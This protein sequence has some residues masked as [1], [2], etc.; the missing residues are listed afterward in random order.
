[1]PASFDADAAPRRAGRLDAAE[2]AEAEREL[3]EASALVERLDQQIEARAHTLPIYVATLDTDGLG[4]ELRARR[5]HPLHKLL[6][7]MYHEDRAAA[8]AAD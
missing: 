2:T 8:P 4:A 1:M 6:R 7:R 3:A 5:D